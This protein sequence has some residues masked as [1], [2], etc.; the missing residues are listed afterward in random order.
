MFRRDSSSDEPRICSKT[1]LTLVPSPSDPV[2]RVAKPSF[3]AMNPKV[4]SGPDRQ[5]WG[6]YDVAGGRTIYGAAP[7]RAA[8]GE[9]LAAQRVAESLSA[10][11]LGE[12]FVDASKQEGLTTL[13]E[14]VERE[15]AERHHMQPKQIAKQWRAERREYSLTL[16]ETG[17]FVDIETAE[18][19][20]ALRQVAAPLLVE[21]GAP[22]LTLAHLKSEDRALTTQLAGWVRSQVLDDGSLPHGI[23][24]TSKHS[25]D[26]RCW[27][28]WLRALDDG[29]DLDSEPTRAGK[30][31]DIEPCERNEELEHVA[32][33]FD[34]RVH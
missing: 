20:A 29:K 16:P 21:R 5:T 28:I 25:Q 15:W 11:T 30:G 17:W 9:S 4:R 10:T 6:R 24:Y 34:L 27:A 1:S 3:G 7:V 2:L 31:Q 23:A 12:L 32:N 33:L 26:W 18:S 19:I 8:Y 22:Q 14:A 13:L